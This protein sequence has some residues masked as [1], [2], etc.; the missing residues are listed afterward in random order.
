MIGFVTSRSAFAALGARDPRHELL[1]RSQWADPAAEEAPDHR[2]EGQQTDRRQQDRF[3]QQADVQLVVELAQEE[4][5]KQPA[6]QRAIEKGQ[7]LRPG[8]RPASDAPVAQLDDVVVFRHPVN[9]SDFIK[10]L[11][12][13][14]ARTARVV[15]DEGELDIPI[16]QVE[17]DNRIRVRPG[18]KLPVDGVVIEGQTVQRDDLLCTLGDEIA[19]GHLHGSVDDGTAERLDLPGLDA[20]RVDIIVAG[21]T[22]TRIHPIRTVHVALQEEVAEDRSDPAT[23]SRPFDRGRTGMVL[24]EGS[25]AVIIEGLDSA[26]A[27]G[28]TIFGEVVGQGIVDP[29]R[30]SLRVARGERQGPQ[31]EFRADGDHG[32]P[33]TQR[34]QNCGDEPVNMKQRHDVQAEV[35]RR[36][37]ET[38][39][40][41]VSRNAQV[42]LRQGHDLRSRRRA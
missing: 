41:I 18:E 23:M 4:G 17:L 10:R 38:G 40:N 28:A 8:A 29:D 24:G 25:G 6:E 7:V 30:G 21:A 3:V 27:R 26:Q 19:A 36:Q 13:L 14:Q 5:L 34:S 22:G 1:Q 33:G 31:L 16:E 15:R 32:S 11:I 20:R 39:S 9:G 2:R 37:C 42:G 35:L 12:G